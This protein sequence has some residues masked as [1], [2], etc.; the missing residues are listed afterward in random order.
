MHLHSAP[1]ERIWRPLQNN[2]TLVEA[3]I[4]MPKTL[5]IRSTNEDNINNS[6]SGKNILIPSLKNTSFKIKFKN[7]IVSFMGDID[8]FPFLIL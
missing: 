4:G 6:E 1:K 5:K 3:P 8:D 7:L 2:I